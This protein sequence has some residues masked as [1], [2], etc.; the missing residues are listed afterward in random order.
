MTTP[1]NWRSKI[2]LF[3]IEVT[4]GL[5]PVPVVATDA[6]LATDVQLRPMEGS[7]VNRDLDLPYYGPQGTIP[8]ELHQKLSFKVELAPSGTAGT[9]PA[10]G[11]LLRACGCAQTVNAG[12]NVIYNPITDNQASGTFYIWIGTTR[13]AITG[14]RGTAKFTINAQGIPYIEFEFTG[15]FTQPAETARGNPVLTAFRAPRVVS[16]ANTPTFTINGV[17]LVMR[18]FQLDLGNQVEPRFLV[19]AEGILITQREDMIKTQVEAEALTLINPFQLAAAQTAV[20]VNLVHGIGAGNIA[21]LNAPTAQM[22]RPQ[23]L[24]NA[25]GIKEWPLSL[26]PLPTGAGNNQ[27]TLTLT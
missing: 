4:Y 18:T 12:T 21:T 17:S 20:A 10:W 6:I 24:E 26:Q 23:G 27:W 13:Y 1:L 25:Q 7:D 5:D 15:L 22:Q 8:N 9:A 2:L 16:S 11:P 14:C 3:K 19:G